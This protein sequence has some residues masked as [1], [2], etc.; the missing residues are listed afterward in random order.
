MQTYFVYFK[1]VK[2]MDR[3]KRFAE[4]IFTAW[5]TVLKEVS[6]AVQKASH[7]YIFSY[8]GTDRIRFTGLSYKAYSQP[9]AFGSP[10]IDLLCDN[11][12]IL[13]N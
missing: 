8:D 5:Q 6:H 9:N 2:R 11:L 3:G 10:K 1:S 4:K 13:Q 7:V 12:I